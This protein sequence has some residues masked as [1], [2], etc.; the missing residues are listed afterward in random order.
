MIQSTSLA[1]AILT[2]ATPT[3]TLIFASSFLWLW[4]YQHRSR[5][6]L[7]LAGAY[8]C[9]VLGAAT[10]ISKI[11]SGTAPNAVVSTLFYTLSTLMLMEGM[12]RRTGEGLEIGL[13]AAIFT[14]LVGGIAYFSYVDGNLV[15]RILINNFGT[16]MALL[17]ITPRLKP[18]RNANGIN[19]LLYWVYLA[20]ALSFF[21]R[22]AL[23]V[24]VHPLGPSDKFAHSA[25]WIMLQFSMLFF[26]VLLTLVL[27]V[28]S[29]ID[30]IDRLRS[31]RDVDPLTGLLNRR[32]FNDHV[33]AKMARLPKGAS[34]SL[35]VC[36]LDHFKRINDTFGHPAGDVVLREFGGIVL[37]AIRKGDVAGRVGGE[38]FVV[39]LPDADYAGA[40]EL[41]ERM[42][43]KL[44]DHPFSSLPASY[45]VTGSFGV[46]VL[47]PGESIDELLERADRMLYAAKSEGRNRV[48]HVGRHA[49][50]ANGA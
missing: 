17:F 7:F 44:M 31:E 15:A 22:T 49:G 9:F 10:Q 39:L 21:L 5:Y 14:T 11:P 40:T 3:L 32:G 25:F 41:A 4:K 29:M 37:S 2:L 43:V 19:V 48:V 27:L 47:R 33:H 6:L 36:D 20:F 35:I 34:V 23:T 24:N 1:S 50:S 46:A 30:R 8:L 12:L 38:E 16:G 26:A 45:S 18:L 42:R 13:H 28:A